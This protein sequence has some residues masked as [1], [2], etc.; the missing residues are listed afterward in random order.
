MKMLT[1]KQNF[2][3]QKNTYIARNINKQECTEMIIPYNLAGNY[4]RKNEPAACMILN[5]ATLAIK[6]GVQFLNSHF[7]A[8]DPEFAKAAKR[9]GPFF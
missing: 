4:I 3:R 9:I 6:A 2:T 8:I 5:N 1:V 7:N